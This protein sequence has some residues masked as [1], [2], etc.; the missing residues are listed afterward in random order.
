MK[1]CL[2]KVKGSNSPALKG[3][4]ERSCL[5]FNYLVFFSSG[6][7]CDPSW[8]QIR[9]VPLK[10]LNCVAVRSK[11][12]VMDVVSTSFE[13]TKL[14][15]VTLTNPTMTCSCALCFDGDVDLN[16]TSKATYVRSISL[17]KKSHKHTPLRFIEEHIWEYKRLPETD[18][19]LSID[20]S[21][22]H[23]HH[24]ILPK[25]LYVRKSCLYYQR[26]N[27]EFNADWLIRTQSFYFPGFLRDG[28]Q[29]EC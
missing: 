22:F 9:S 3:H 8:R 10:R 1:L 7:F 29:D 26:I 21:H 16:R 2:P 4:A 15:W 25:V 11:E 17:T 14:F 23:R 18:R 12:V 24:N 20:R 13:D 28:C 27:W 19:R 5:W 6:C